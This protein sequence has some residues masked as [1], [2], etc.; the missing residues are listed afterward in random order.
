[1][2]I[3][4]N[5]NFDFLGKK[6]PFII[7]SLVLTAAGL[8]S[9]IA[10][11]RS[12]LRHRFPGRSLMYVLFD[13]KP[14]VDKIRGALSAQ[15]PGEIS[16]VNVASSNE[17][18]IGTEIQEERS[19][20]P[21]RQKMVEVLDSTFGQSGKLDLNNSG[22]AALGRTAARSAAACGRGAVRRTDSEPGE[23]GDRVQ[24]Y[25]ALRPA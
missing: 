20:N 9:L 8:V 11:G 3:F 15:I 14:P 25:A 19:L 17:V 23:G 5:T 18:I 24:G 13:Q 21:N 7:L 6:W 16:V 4:K 10:K 2:E 22:A 12:A 1:M